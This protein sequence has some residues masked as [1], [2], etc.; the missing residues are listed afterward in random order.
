YRQVA[1]IVIRQV[2]LEYL[3]IQEPLLFQYSNLF[4]DIFQLPYVARPG[5]VCKELLCILRKLYVGTTVFIGKISDK[6]AEEQVDVF[7]SVT[8]GWD[9]QRYGVEAVVQVFSEF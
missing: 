2:L 1:P 4:R 7:L 3:R 5:I 9:A 6:F 8:Q